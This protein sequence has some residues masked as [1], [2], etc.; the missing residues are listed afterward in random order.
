[1]LCVKLDSEA[2][3]KTGRYMDKDRVSNRNFP[4]KTKQDC[5]RG[6]KIYKS[7]VEKASLQKDG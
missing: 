5:T 7:S 4:L 1:M 2:E 3:T 6:D